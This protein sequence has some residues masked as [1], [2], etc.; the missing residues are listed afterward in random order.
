M[1]SRQLGR[2]IK[3][4][5]SALRVTQE[6]LCAKA[7]VSRAVLSK[8]ESER[9]DPVQTDV[10]ER[11]LA[12]LGVTVTVGPG[13]SASAKALERLKHRQRE[14]ERRERHLRLALDLCANPVKAGPKIRRA[15]RQVDLWQQNRSCSRTYIEGWRKALSHDP[16]RVALAMTSFGEWENA[17]YQN[18]PW[19]FLWT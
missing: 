11:L 16:R 6:A 13:E 2:H 18:S 3:S 19:S 5:R 7:Q 8:L 12:A 14:Q 1:L 9:G 4:R 17:M 15:L 10:V